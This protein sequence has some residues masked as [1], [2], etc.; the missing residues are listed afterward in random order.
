M[1]AVKIDGYGQAAI[2]SQEEIALLFNEGLQTPRDRAVFGCCLYAATR[3]AEACALRKVDVFDSQ[4]RV[5]PAIV[6]RKGNTKGKL[7]T[8]TIPT[9][10]DLRL[11]LLAYQPHLFPENPYLFP[12]RHPRH[13]WK[14]L[15]PEAA[16][17]ILR[18]A[19][20]RVGL[21]GVSTHSFRRT[22]LTQM[23]NEGIPLRVIQEVSGH[24]TLSELQKYLEVTDAQVKGAIAALSALSYTKKTSYSN[25]E[26]ESLNFP[27]DVANFPENTPSDAPC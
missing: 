23:S 14:H 3:I 12:P 1:T 13:H 16:D 9:H 22:A 24:R 5:R 2:L 10:P 17:R 6:L 19:C 26:A 21:E 7:A 27:S 4:E 8:R 20:K 11:L 15:T 18:G 25:L